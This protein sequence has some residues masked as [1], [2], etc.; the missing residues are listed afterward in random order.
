MTNAADQ[1][2]TPEEQDE[3][4]TEKFIEMLHMPEDQR[5]P[6]FYKIKELLLN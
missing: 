4:A 2:L 1:I 6:V 3:A 5:S